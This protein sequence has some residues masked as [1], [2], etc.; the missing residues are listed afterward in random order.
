[1]D[2][3]A[4]SLGTAEGRASLVGSSVAYAP[5]QATPFPPFLTQ[6]GPPGSMGA[7]AH[8][9]VFNANPAESLEAT[10]HEFRL[11]RTSENLTARI[12]LYYSENDDDDSGVFYFLPPAI[13]R[14][15]AAC[16]CPKATA[17]S[18]AGIWRSCRSCRT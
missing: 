1:M 5:V 3:E 17:P 7:I 8:A 18:R 10:S 11:T 14:R 13:A 15:T 4:N 2:H 16:A 12:G 6:L 9:S